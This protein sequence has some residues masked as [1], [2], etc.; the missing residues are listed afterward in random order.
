[1]PRDAI[2]VLALAAASLQ[3]GAARADAPALL[4]AT[5][6]G[7]SEAQRQQLAAALQERLASSGV[8]L[9]PADDVTHRLASAT[10]LGLTC[11]GDDVE[12]LLKLGT[13]A[14]LPELLAP[15]AFEADGTWFLKLTLVQVSPPQVLGTAQAPI[16]FG[17]EGADVSGPVMALFEPERY[18]GRLELRGVPA[19]AHVYIDGLE[20]AVAP[21][22]GPLD[23]V[24]VGVRRV[25]VV[26]DG[27]PPLTTSAVVRF[28]EVTVLDLGVA[29][30]VA[31]TPSTAE[32]PAVEARAPDEDKLLEEPE[33]EA[34]GI[35]PAALALF[36]TGG[37]VA[38]LGVV[39]AVLGGGAAATTEA[40]LWTTVG[41]YEQRITMQYSGLAGLGALAASG[42]FLGA[43]GLLLV[44]GLLL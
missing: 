28:G 23:G 1:M 7:L 36:G 25:R 11:S 31:G 16:A 18:V 12:C 19:G 2:L 34:S 44:V 17:P 4:P 6:E 26:V 13:L 15:W 42:V 35:S 43:G 41:S 33:T 24:A 40:L 5:G 39:L 9:Q 8:A 3:A 37:A 20:R 30:P 21:L 22:A 29:A 10:G 38:G 27:A 32:P 14:G